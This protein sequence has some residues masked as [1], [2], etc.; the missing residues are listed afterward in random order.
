MDSGYIFSVFVLGGVAFH[1][2]WNAA[3]FIDR[4]STS[5]G[6][7]ERKTGRHATRDDWYMFFHRSD[8]TGMQERSPQQA[9]ISMPRST[10]QNTRRQ[11]PS[12]RVH[13]S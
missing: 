4:L 9:H 13:M 5:H 11:R 10:S 3:S 6:R 7:K 8:L 12:V 1:L 2:I